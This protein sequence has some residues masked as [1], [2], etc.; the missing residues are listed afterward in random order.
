MP[1]GW[2]AF[3]TCQSFDCA[4]PRHIK[5][6]AGEA[7]GQGADRPRRVPWQRENARKACHAKRIKLSAEMRQWVAEQP[8]SAPRSP[9]RWT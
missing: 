7:Y 1:E 3:R 4:N 8:V 2:R 9:T 5:A 6:G